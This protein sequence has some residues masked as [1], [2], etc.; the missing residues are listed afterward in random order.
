M[1]RISK[2]GNLLKEKLTKTNQSIEKGLQII[3]ILSRQ[4][5]AMRLQDI[6]EAAEIPA[7]TVMR[8]LKALSKYDYVAQHEE[9]AKYSL[10]L[11]FAQI[12]SLVKSQFSI[13]EVVRPYLVDLSKKCHESICLAIE[14]D[15]EVVYI[16]TV[17]GPDSMLTTMQ[18]IGKRA[19]LHSTGVG[20]LMLL[21]F[22]AVKLD[23]YIA[24]TGLRALTKNTITGKDQLIL[25]L[26]GIRKKNFAIDDEECE[27]GARCVAA[28]IRD[29][30]GNVIAS[31][32]IS[33]PAI[34]MTD[35]KID[36][37]K[38]DIRDTAIKISRVYGYTPA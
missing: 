14:Q 24:R 11:K 8:L 4:K 38:N 22:D 20:K 30:S 16:D 10:T 18:R 31:I 7:S 35:A 17:D 36:S 28:P 2:R 19:P 25:A 1:S 33:G 32:S 12:G 26:E 3:E 27:L 37:V 13:N 15:M 23:A 29:Y 6:S 34:R 5:G 21:N 9:T